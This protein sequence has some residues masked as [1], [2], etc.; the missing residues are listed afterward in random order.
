TTSIEELISQRLWITR[1]RHDDDEVRGAA[2]HTLL[3]LRLDGR[4]HRHGGN[5]RHESSWCVQGFLQEEI[6]ARRA[7]STAG[8]HPTSICGGASRFFGTSLCR[9]PLAST[10]SSTRAS[11]TSRQARADQRQNEPCDPEHG[12]HAGGTR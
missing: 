12:Q 11:S 7:C 4:S 8:K 6:R 3:A 9:A 2:I 1:E 5:H 10:F